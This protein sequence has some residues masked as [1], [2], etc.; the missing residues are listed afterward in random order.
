[1][2]IIVAQINTHVADFQANLVKM[3]GVIDKAK[4]DQADVVVFPELSLCGYPP[5]DLLLRQDFLDASDAAVDH[6]RQ[7]ADGIAIVVGAPRKTVQ[8]LHNAAI[9]LHQRRILL[10]YYKHELPNYGVFDEARYFVKGHQAGVFQLQ[11]AGARIGLLICEDTWFCQP[12]LKAKAA[13]ADCLISIHASPYAQDKEPLRQGVYRRCVQ[14][15][16]LPLLCCQTVGAQDDLVFDGGSKAFA[17]NGDVSFAAAYCQEQVSPVHFIEGCFTGERIAEPKPITKMYQALVLGIKDY[18]TKNGFQQLY[19][20]L[21][22]GIDSSLTLALAVDAVG[23]DRVHAV[24]MPSRFTSQASLEAVRQQLALLPVQSQELSIE[25]MFEAALHTLAPHFPR[26]AWDKTEENVQAR[27][28]GLLLMAMANKHGGMVL[29]TSNKS[30]MAVGYS[31]LYGDMVGGFAAL[32]DVPKTSVFQLAHYRNT[33][34][35][36]IPEFIIDR[37]PTAELAF[38]QTDQ[39][40]LPPY[41]ILDDIIER[42]V[43]RQESIESIVSA[44]FNQATV[45]RV[46]NMIVQ[47]EYKRRQAPPGVKITSKAFARERRYPMTAA[48][49]WLTKTAKNGD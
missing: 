3:K 42:F 47:N 33:I 41:E 20:G 35:P 11:E 49:Q 14:L 45:I 15:T 23:L 25:P 13:G 26:D 17:I 29:N 10:E 4:L 12:A 18:V 38:D 48:Y 5:E 30:E 27:I 28:R 32:K 8:G 2:K 31:T 43:D 40:T 37:P 22:G 1:M 6:L 19:I 36:T 21:S 44:G 39:D 46:V 24:V 16:Q 34:A 9:V 7:Q